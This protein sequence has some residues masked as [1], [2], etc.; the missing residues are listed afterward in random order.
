MLGCHGEQKGICDAFQ[1]WFRS[2]TSCFRS[3][4]SRELVCLRV[5]P[6]FCCFTATCYFAMSISGSCTFWIA[7]PIH[8]NKLGKIRASTQKEARWNS[9]DRSSIS[10][11]K[12]LRSASRDSDS[13][14]SPFP[15][16]PERR[17]PL[18]P[19]KFTLLQLFFPILIT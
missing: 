5:I 13:A 9:L 6:T 4:L 2:E 14:I 7:S 1:S 10:S 11:G 8:Q 15:S 18:E 19:R 17:E 3:L 12:I 16:C